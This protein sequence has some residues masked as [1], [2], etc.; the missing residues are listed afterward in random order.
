MTAQLSLTDEQPRSRVVCSFFAPGKVRGKGNMGIHPKTGRIYDAT[1]KLGPWTKVL[2][3][4]A[5][6][7]MD[8]ELVPCPAPILV[9]VVFCFERPKG[10]YKASGGLSAKATLRPV[11]KRRDD[12]DKLVRAILDA[13][14]GIA[15]EDDAQ[16]VELTASKAWADGRGVGAAVAVE[17]L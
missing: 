14:T 3:G 13:L 2:R 4:C 10:H 8:G 7:A 17:R 6:A 5:R 1:P 9:D 15:F 12:V 11:Q 16:V